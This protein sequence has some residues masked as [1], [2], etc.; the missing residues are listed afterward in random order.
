[1]EKKKTNYFS[2]FGLR[3][4]CD[5]SMLLGAVLLIVGLFVSL[6]SLKAAYILLRIGLGIYIIAT[7]LSLIRTIRVIVTVKNRR[8]PEYKR[9]VINTV[10]VAV[11]FA[12]AVFGFVY[13]LVA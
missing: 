5:I 13:L 12:V 2:N 11:I 3:Q 10:I 4:I 9:A 7:A 8:N 1:M 6:G